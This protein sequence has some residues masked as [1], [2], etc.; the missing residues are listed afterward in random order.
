[1]G[2]AGV[3]LSQVSRPKDLSIAR[4]FFVF[5]Q[6][7]SRWWGSVCI[8]S[9]EACAQATWV[10]LM[11]AEKTV[12]FELVRRYSI[13]SR[14]AATKPPVLARDFDMLPQMTSTLSLRPK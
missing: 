8:S 6:S 14:E 7:F 5:D 1:M 3:S 13:T 10:G 12:C 11:A 4:Y 2:T 9:S